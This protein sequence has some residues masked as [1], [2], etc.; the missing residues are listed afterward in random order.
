MYP[1]SPPA[2]KYI[3][4]L[5]AR[6]SS[7]ATR[8]TTAIRSGFDNNPV[9]SSAELPALLWQ[10][11]GFRF[12]I[13]CLRPHRYARSIPFHF[14]C[15][16]LTHPYHRCAYFPT[17]NVRTSRL[18]R[19]RLLWFLPA[20]RFPLRLLA[21]ALAFL[22]YPPAPVLYPVRRSRWSSSSLS[23]AYSAYV[24]VLKL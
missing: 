13:P 10:T 18:R 1:S 14:Q 5:T 15:I 7:T 2:R 16:F 9:V 20:G 8:T 12:L 19:Y 22:V 23:S 17:A 11:G 4:V 24:A 21:L 6:L 3:P